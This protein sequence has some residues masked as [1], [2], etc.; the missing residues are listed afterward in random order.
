M[1]FVVPQAKITNYLLKDFGK[2]QFF[3]AQGYTAQ[4][5]QVLRRDLILLAQTFPRTLRQQSKYGDEY[6]IIGA[7]VAPNG[8]T[9]R[10]KTGWIIDSGETPTMRFVT[11]YPA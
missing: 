9:I 4:N 7:V 5:W 6:E 1:N 2:R 8:K 10:L 11:A 3:Q